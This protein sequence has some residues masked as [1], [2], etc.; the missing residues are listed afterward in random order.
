M[1][2]LACALL[3]LTLSSCAIRSAPLFQQNRRMMELQRE[4]DKLKRLSDP[5]SRAKTEIT[6]SEIL[7][8]LSR[9]AARSGDIEVLGHHLEEYVSTIRDAH[10]TMM[11]TGKDAHKSPKGFRELEIALRKQVNQLKDIG[12]ELTLDQREAVDK[13]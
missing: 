2:N 1:K 13:A 9:D 6:I 3:V 7:L 12:G 4:K 11:K 5:V 10:E 8:D